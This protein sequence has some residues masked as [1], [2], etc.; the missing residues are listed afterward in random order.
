MNIMRCPVTFLRI[1][2]PKI[3][4]SPDKR[5]EPSAKDHS[6][7]YCGSSTNFLWILGIRGTGLNQLEPGWIRNISK[8]MYIYYI[9][10]CACDILQ[11]RKSASFRSTMR[12]NGLWASQGSPKCRPLGLPEVAPQD[13][14][15]KIILLTIVGNDG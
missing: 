4:L 12:A 2:A 13:R 1:A 15:G 5:E 9:Y 14:C 6:K 7:M 10:I 3:F 8:T 11:T